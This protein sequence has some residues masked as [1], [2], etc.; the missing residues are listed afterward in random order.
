MTTAQD[1]L[2]ARVR[3]Y[4][5]HNAAKEP[6]AIRALVQKGQDQLLGLIDGLTEEQAAFKPGPDDWSVLE[7]MA[8]IVTAKRGVA[9]ICRRLARGERVSDFGGEREEQDGIARGA[10]AS[11][12]EARAALKEA[13]GELLAFVDT[14]SPETNVEARC[15]HFLFGPL[16]CKEWAVL[17]RVHDG[18]HAG[19]LEQI[20]AAPGFPT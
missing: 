8:H 6:P 14:L 7:L 18:D 2:S 15:E 13:D 11:L 12:A 1:E 10:F 9:R 17:Q 16:N 4:I 5:E 20:K 3:A 19:Q